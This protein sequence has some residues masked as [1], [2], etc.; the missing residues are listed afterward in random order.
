MQTSSQAARA[1]EAASIHRSARS[2]EADV[3]RRAI[4][5]LKAAENGGPLARW[6]ITGGC[7]WSSTI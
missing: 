1:Y 7:G 5:A 4:G 6:R 3:F 2:Q